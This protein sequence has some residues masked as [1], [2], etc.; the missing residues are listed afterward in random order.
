MSEK[1]GIEEGPPIWVESALSKEEYTQSHKRYPSTV[2]SPSAPLYDVKRYKGGKW[3]ANM[4][5]SLSSSE[6]TNIN[7][8]IDYLLENVT[9][10]S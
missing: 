9:V 10:E 3:R 5:G 8:N 2:T 4:G 1:K 7:K 6:I